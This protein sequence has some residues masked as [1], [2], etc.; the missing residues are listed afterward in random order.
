[1]L[2]YPEL[3]AMSPVQ[4]V[5]SFRI[6]YLGEQPSLWSWQS[7][8]LLWN[9]NWPVGRPLLVFI[10]ERMFGS[11]WAPALNT[12]KAT[13][14][15]RRLVN[16]RQLQDWWITFA[17]NSM[18]ANT[19]SY[20]TTKPIS[21]FVKP[22]FLLKPVRQLTNA[23]NLND[24]LIINID[25]ILF[26]IR[27]IR[28]KTKEGCWPSSSRRYV[29][30]S[31]ISRLRISKMQRWSNSKSKL[32]NSTDRYWSTRK[33]GRYAEPRKANQIQERHRESHA[34]YQ[35]HVVIS[36]VA[37]YQEDRPLS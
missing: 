8:E 34:R 28:C 3:T 31:F 1:M 16:L 2:D 14:C 22:K 15:A 24:A 18:R 10:K 23:L 37:Q 5:G 30:F 17:I 29:K 11:R 19:S 35:V 7:Q 32:T 33:S 4:S 26:R 13:R 12:I 6:P 9:Y 27:H 21:P 20:P 36:V 25:I